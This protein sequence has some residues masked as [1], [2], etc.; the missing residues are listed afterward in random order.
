MSEALVVL[1]RSIIGFF[2]LLIF[3]RL[4]GKQQISQLTF[5]DYVLGITVGSIAASLSV[6]LSSR[7]WPHWVGLLTWTVLVLALQILT[8]KS[9]VAAKFFSGEP[10]VV[11]SNGKILEDAMKKTRYTVSDLMEQLRDKNIFDLTEVQFAVL[12]TDGQLSVQL[13]PE[14]RPVT[15]KDMNLMPAD[16][17]LSA[18]LIYNGMIIEENLE[19]VGLDRLWLEQQLQQQGIEKVTDVF[20]AS[21]NPAASTLY[22][23]LYSDNLESSTKKPN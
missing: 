7:A 23:D 9:P 5:F 12:E 3:A 21:Y 1:V 17:G 14:L 4:L 10:T 19:L 20:L 18:Q 2:S 13:K 6:D 15:V 8:I 11:I 22:I 16:S